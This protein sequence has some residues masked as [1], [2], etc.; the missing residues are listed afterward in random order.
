[1]HPIHN[2]VLCTGIALIVMTYSLH[3]SSLLKSYVRWELRTSDL[4]ELSLV[5][6]RLNSRMK[7]KIF[8]D[9]IGPIVGMLFWLSALFVR[10]YPTD[11]T[12]KAYK[13]YYYLSTG[14]WQTLVLPCILISFLH[15]IYLLFVLIDDAGFIESYASN[16]VFN[17]F[18]GLS[19]DVTIR[20][21][22][23]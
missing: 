23:L 18:E 22:F 6:K 8:L 7:W 2:C 17:S 14:L 4:G 12:E 19:S 15:S 16:K 5:E 3:A 10:V 13:I 9:L 20:E 11:L 1:M 21:L